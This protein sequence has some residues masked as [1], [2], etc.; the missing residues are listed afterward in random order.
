MNCAGREALFLFPVLVTDFL[1][2]V[3]W[4]SLIKHYEATSLSHFYALS[5]SILAAEDCSSSLMGDKESE[6]YL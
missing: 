3:W 5:S 1:P 6:P 2:S 4:D